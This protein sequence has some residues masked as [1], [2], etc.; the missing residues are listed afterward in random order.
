MAQVL[1]PLHPCTWETWVNFQAPNPAWPSPG[2]SGHLGNE[3]Q[4]ENL[5]VYTLCVHN[6][7]FQINKNMFKKLAQ[8][9]LEG[10]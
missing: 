10:S 6:C 2:C 9:R 1:G 3:Q 7:A 8:V 4:M 5:C